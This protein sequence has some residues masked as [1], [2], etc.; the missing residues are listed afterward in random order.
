MIRQKPEASFSW[1][2]L[3]KRRG[4]A[5]KG[6]ILQLHDKILIRFKLDLRVG[7]LYTFYSIAPLIVILELWMIK[8]AHSLASSRLNRSLLFFTNLRNNHRSKST[9]DLVKAIAN[10]LKVSPK[11]QTRS[12]NIYS[13]LDIPTRKASRLS[14]HQ[15]LPGSGRSLS[16]LLSFSY[17][18]D[19]KHMKDGGSCA[20][21]GGA[22]AKYGNLRRGRRV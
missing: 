3:R 7:R 4:P 18:N 5:S 21:G 2:T 13:L 19:K 16:D 14:L 1:T 12:R 22:P 15:T 17:T 10:L 9:Q 6:A 20:H 8:N 11:F